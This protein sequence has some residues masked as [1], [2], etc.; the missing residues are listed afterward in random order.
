MGF[1][2]TK[3]QPFTP[4]FMNTNFTL[5]RREKSLESTQQQLG[6]VNNLSVWKEMRS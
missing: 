4:I 3:T 1:E 2:T 6:R 5:N